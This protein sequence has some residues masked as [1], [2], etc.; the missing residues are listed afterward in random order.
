MP[1]KSEHRRCSIFVKKQSYPII[2]NTIG[3]QLF[4][5]AVTVYTVTGHIVLHCFVV[6]PITESP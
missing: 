3:V 2:R 5:R 4:P 6:I 1:Q